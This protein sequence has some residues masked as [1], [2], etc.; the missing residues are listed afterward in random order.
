MPVIIKKYIFQKIDLRIL[1]S[2]IIGG[3][4]ISYVHEDQT[5]FTTNNYP[6]FNYRLS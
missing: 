5:N 6:N 4:S 3:G 1:T 2:V